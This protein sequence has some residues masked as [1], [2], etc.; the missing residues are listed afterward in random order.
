VLAATLH[1]GLVVACGAGEAVALLTVQT[2]GKKPLS[3]PEF[4]RG[5]GLA[6]GAMLV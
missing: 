3:A 6:V 4:L 1:E 2:E 5:H